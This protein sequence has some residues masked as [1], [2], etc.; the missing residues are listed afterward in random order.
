MTRTDELQ[1]LDDAAHLIDTGRQFENMRT[2]PAYGTAEW[3]AEVMKSFPQLRGGLEWK[4]AA[5][6]TYL[7]NLIAKRDRLNELIERLESGN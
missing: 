4:V 2:T 7:E 1:R 5:D 3:H 6:A